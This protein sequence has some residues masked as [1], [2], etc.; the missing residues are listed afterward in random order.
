M[1]QNWIL[2]YLNSWGYIYLESHSVAAYGYTISVLQCQLAWMY[3]TAFSI[4]RSQKKSQRLCL[5]CVHPRW[6]FSANWSMKHTLTHPWFQIRVTPSCRWS[7]PE[8]WW[9][10]CL[11]VCFLFSL[12]GEKRSHKNAGWN[13]GVMFFL[14]WTVMR[15]AG[16]AMQHFCPALWCSWRKLEQTRNVKASHAHLFRRQASSTL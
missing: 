8:P 10:L 11:L 9:V 5:N 3:S 4:V 12:T 1:S 6:C 7:P 13:G 16:G 14:S 15:R 2:S